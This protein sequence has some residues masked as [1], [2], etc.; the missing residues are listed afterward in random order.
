MKSEQI[1][2]LMLAL[3]QAQ[4][5][6]RHA[7]KD[8][9]NPFFKSKYADL[10]SVIDACR[11]SLSKHQLAVVQTIQNDEHG[12]QLVTYL[13]HSSGQWITSSMPVLSKDNTPQAVG[14]AITYARRYSLAAL[15]GVAQEDDDGENAMGRQ[16]LAI[17]T[18]NKIN[19]QQVNALSDMFSKLEEES[20]KKLLKFMQ[21]SSIE[22]LTVDKFKKAYALIEKQYMEVANVA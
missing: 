18:H 20:K 11:S 6:M 5:E 1:D 10:P 8:S 12:I 19:S 9:N 7:T 13:G 16:S 3:S 21:V 2:Q 15:V 17:T 22:D 14:S 4:G